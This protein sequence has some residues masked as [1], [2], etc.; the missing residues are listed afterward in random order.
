MTNQKEQMQDLK[1]TQEDWM[2][3]KWRPAMGWTYMA[4]CIFDFILGPILYNV[5]QYHNPGQAVGM[6]TPLTLQGGGMYHIAMGAILGISAWSRGQEK[7]AGQSNTDVVVQQPVMMSQPEPSYNAPKTNYAP[8][9]MMSPASYTPEPSYNAPMSA[10]VNTPI[11][12]S[13]RPTR[14]RPNF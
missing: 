7:I 3:K 8:E 5:L 11:N 9:P 12:T 14:K 4:T 6:W 13:G 1:V 10:P 2:V